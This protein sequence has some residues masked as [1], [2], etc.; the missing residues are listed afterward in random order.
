L[1]RQLCGSR[2]DCVPICG[3]DA[4]DV[5]CVV[6]SRLAGQ[7]AITVD[8]DSKCIFCGND[9]G[10]KV[11]GDDRCRVVI[12]DEAFVGFC[13]VIWTAHVREITDLSTAERSHLMEVVFAVESALR[14]LLRPHKMNLAS[15]GNQVPHL[16]WHVVPRFISDSHFPEP[17]W[18]VRQR[19]PAPHAWPAGFASALA[20]R[21]AS[22]HDER[23]SQ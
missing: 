13:R 5:P 17:V 20:Q 9:G 3:N 4:P 6:T 15:L 8:M 19:D 14:A 7:N 21:L 22:C 18:G 10:L 16:H 12:A 2:R 1:V 11:Y 23:R